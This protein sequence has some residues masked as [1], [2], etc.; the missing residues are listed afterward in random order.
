MLPGPPSPASKQAAGLEA[1]ELAWGPE[2]RRLF[3]GRPGWKSQLYSLSVFSVF[4]CRQYTGAKSSKPLQGALSVGSPHSQITLS[5][6]T[7]AV[8]GFQ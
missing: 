6:E 5:R 3:S 7:G 4:S 1:P 2:R 8:I